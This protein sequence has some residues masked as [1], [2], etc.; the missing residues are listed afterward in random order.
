MR[1]CCSKMSSLFVTFLS[2]IASSFLTRAALQAEILALR[3]QLTVLQGSG[4]NRATIATTR[5]IR[6]AQPTIG[7]AQCNGYGSVA[8]TTT[9]TANRNRSE[10][11]D[12]DLKPG[13]VGSI[14]SKLM[15][16]PEFATSIRIMPRSIRIAMTKSALRNSDLP[17]AMRLREGQGRNLCRSRGTCGLDADAGK[18]DRHL[19]VHRDFTKQCPCG[20]DLRDRHI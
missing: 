20:A 10:A 12:P 6:L 13:S 1:S 17:T 11:R 8:M 9:T 4:A 2:L 14:L 5:P 7:R 18:I 16:L 15:N 19:A 3:H